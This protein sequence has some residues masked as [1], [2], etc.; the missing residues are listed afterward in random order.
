MKR[1]FHTTRAIIESQEKEKEK[2]KEM[3]KGKEN[4]QNYVE[5]K[6]PFKLPSIFSD[7]AFNTN[8]DSQL[9]K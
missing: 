3:G 8:Y 5:Y 4:K 2:E 1:N 9:V 6:N 7:K